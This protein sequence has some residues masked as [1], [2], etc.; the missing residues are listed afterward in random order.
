M[1]SRVSSVKKYHLTP[2]LVL[3]LACIIHFICVFM[4]I[5]NTLDG[6]TVPYEEYT[7]RQIVGV[8]SPHITNGL[9]ALAA[10]AY[11][12]FDYFKYLHSKKEIDFYESLPIT[13]S[14]RFISN[15]I[16]GFSVYAIMLL[17]TLCFELFVATL[18]GV[19]FHLI[20]SGAFWNYVC[21]I[22]IYLVS[23]VTAALAMIMTGHSLV[24][25][26]GY[27]AFSVY[28]PILLYNLIPTFSSMYFETYTKLSTFKH[29][30]FW[31]LF[32]YL[33]PASL[34]YKVTSF[35]TTFWKVSDHVTPLIAMIIFTLIVG[36]IAFK[37]F[38]KRP[39]EAAGRAMTFEKANSI[40]RILLVVPVTLYLGVF[41]KSMSSGE[42]DMWLIFGIIFFGFIFH[43]IIQG[44]F[45]ADIKSV[46]TKKKQLL[47]TYVICFAI[48]SIFKFDIFKYDEFLPKLHKVDKISIETDDFSQYLD[49]KYLDGIT[50]E[51]LALALD[52]AQDLINSTS[53]LSYNFDIERSYIVFEY[54]LKNGM[55]VTRNYV[56][57]INNVSTNLDTLSKTKSFKD[58]YCLFFKKQLSD[59]SSVS[60]TYDHS[61]YIPIE[62][63][64][65]E[66]LID[67]YMEEFQEL[68][69][70]ELYN[71]PVLYRFFAFYDNE[72]F[73]V[74]ETATLDSSYDIHFEEHQ[75]SNYFNVYPSFEKTI[76]IL[77]RLG[78]KS[79]AENE[80]L[81]ITALEIY[82]NDDYLQNQTIVD[83]EILAKL[84]SY[85]YVT[86]YNRHYNE[87][88]FIYGWATVKSGNIE[89]H[90]DLFF[91]Q[92]A[93][94]PILNLEKN[95]AH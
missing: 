87:Q 95:C 13:R 88:K 22:G 7:V 45:E 10:G 24:A 64:D 29:F 62:G 76:E 72:N 39:S 63:K 32:Y 68:S 60:F 86:D 19:E 94:E 73:D 48:L 8:F 80:D 74:R 90:Y 37:L 52:S 79:F 5:Q 20:A 34:L 91:D 46:F 44:I 9:F 30:D 14:K 85:A 69:F 67:V 25:I 82:S 17:I 23:W 83:E 77:N 28:F 36:V 26:L 42:S 53:E 16:C 11:M 89:M 51:D 15:F 6:V 59:F 35:Y 27:G 61:N 21:M 65:L 40:I 1:T 70:T 75:S 56:Y 57:D 50:D 12:A 38:Q 71:E 33:S 47:L 58:D 43:G 55:I 93:I 31:N 4:G 54:H 66:E 81:V 92:S 78:Y 84:K 2:I 3:A 49:S 18:L 41:M